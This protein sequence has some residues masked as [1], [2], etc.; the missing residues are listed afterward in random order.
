MP[1]ALLHGLTLAHPE[2]LY[3]LAIPAIVLLWGIINAREVRRVFAC[4][5]RRSAHMHAVRGVRRMCT[6]SV[7]RSVLR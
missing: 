3:L 7:L 1:I 2:A 4:V 5:R 6:R